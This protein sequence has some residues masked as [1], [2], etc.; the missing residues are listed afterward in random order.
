M[1]SPSDI[2][3]QKVW[4]EIPRDPDYP[5]AEPYRVKAVLTQPTSPP[6]FYARFEEPPRTIHESGLWM[7]FSDAQQAVL[8]HPVIDDYYLDEF[9]DDLE[10]YANEEDELN[11]K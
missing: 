10:A 2:I 3:G 5:M 8:F 6:W 7:S 1:L 11:L 4:L 9:E